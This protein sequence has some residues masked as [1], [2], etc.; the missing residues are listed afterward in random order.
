MPSNK[1]IILTIISVLFIISGIKAI[2]SQQDGRHNTPQIY[3]GAA[4]FN[5]AIFV[6]S[7]IMLA[8][9]VYRKR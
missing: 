5:G 3:G 9:I 1:K 6:A 4:V 2:V 8:F 7:G